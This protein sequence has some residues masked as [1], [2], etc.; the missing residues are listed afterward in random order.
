MW[1]IAG[2]TTGHRR[3]PFVV[4]DIERTKMEIVN[5]FVMDVTTD[6]VLLRMNAVATRDFGRKWQSALRFVIQSVVVGRVKLLE[7]ALARKDTRWILGRDVFRAVILP[8]R[9]GHV[10]I[11]ILASASMDFDR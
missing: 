10:S 2:W 3:N 1:I 8:V 7:G 11:G 9:M 6:A 5:R 4:K